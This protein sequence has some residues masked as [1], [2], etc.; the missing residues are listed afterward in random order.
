MAIPQHSA[1]THKA[2]FDLYYD[3]R[4]MHAVAKQLDIDPHTLR[5]WS[6]GEVA[7]TCPYHNWE[8]LIVE[9]EAALTKRL[10]L[11]DEG[12]VD[13]LA[14]EQA[15]LDL[16]PSRILPTES[17]KAAIRP[18]SKVTDR[19]DRERLS[20]FEFI[21]AKLFYHITG[22]VIDHG[23]LL[24]LTGQT[25]TLEQAQQYFHNR[26]LEPKNLESCIK[27]LLQIT[28]AISELQE[29]LGIRAQRRTTRP[30]ASPAEP[31]RKDATKQIERLCRLRLMS[32]GHSKIVSSAWRQTSS[33]N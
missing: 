5:R 13:P 22:C 28:E 3:L 18:A 12:V 9:R 27:A 4:S 33:N 14:H 1:E 17:Q 25:F 31:P 24:D 15:I 10:E 26:G 21:Y 8:A 19:D 7:C 32:C 29:K 16:E 20:Q 6:R 30:T 11:L 2:A 23:T